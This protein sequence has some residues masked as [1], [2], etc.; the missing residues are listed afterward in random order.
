MS[1]LKFE[2]LARFFCLALLASSSVFAEEKLTTEENTKAGQPDKK[3]E[4]K[5]NHPQEYRVQV[6][7]TLWGISSKFLKDPWLWPNVWSANSQISNPHLIYPGNLIR[8]V[9]INGKPQLTISR[10]GAPMVK[11]SPQGHEIPFDRPIPTIPMNAILPFLTKNRIVSK[12]ELKKAPY[13]VHTQEGRIMA[14]AG[15]VIYVRGIKK[16]THKYFIIMRGGKVYKDPKT[17]EI[18]GY[19]AKFIGDSKMQAFSKK[20]STHYLTKST[21]EVLI[22]DRVFPSDQHITNQSFIPHAPK[23]N[24][25]GR[26][27]AV[28]DGVSQIGQHQV[29]VI[30]RGSRD[31]IEVGHVLGI[32]QKGKKIKDRVRKKRGGVTLPKSKA[33]VIMVFKAFDKLSYAV[34]MRAQ[35]NMSVL[36]AIGK[37]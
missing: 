10:R 13:V 37:P 23:D 20:V 31:G 6:G 33:G 27:I 28:M 18:L 21:R 22:G 5:S 1:K 29:V 30:N 7:D 19:E 14:G 34:V 24:I 35:T 36:D 8:L 32:Y 17:K 11:L 4:L 16:D 26:I 25:D 15:D 9:Y 12:R 2:L 3:I